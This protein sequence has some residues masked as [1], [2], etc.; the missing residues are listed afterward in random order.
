[1]DG[2]LKEPPRQRKPFRGFGPTAVSFGRPALRWLN[3]SIDRAA[4]R[5]EIR[6]QCPDT[7]GVYGMLDRDAQLIYVGMSRDLRSR[8]LSYFVGS[9][10]GSKQ[11][12]IASHAHQLVW[13][14]AGHELTARLRELELIRRWRPRFNAQGRPGRTSLGYVYLTATDAP[15]FRADTVPARGSRW[16]WGPLP[17]ERRTR[18]AAERL[19]HVFQLRDCSRDVPIRFADQRDLFAMDREAACLRG[20]VGGCLA[21]CAGRCTRPEYTRQIDS[22]RALLDGTDLGEL[23]RLQTAM[24]RAAAG[25]QFERAAS[26]RD[27]WDDLAYLV[28]QLELLRDVREH[29]W[30]VYPVPCHTGRTLWIVIAGGDVAGVRRAPENSGTGRRWRE[31]LDDVRRRRDSG[32]LNNLEDLGRIRLAVSWFRQNPAEMDCILTLQEADDYCRRCG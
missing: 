25:Q 32:Q 26:L 12:R 31:L 18:A 21:P 30:F 2:L 20:D 15:Q 13:E 14:V 8:V 24:E 16:S 3:L 1:M 5:R 29:Y 9:D 11:H 17:L 28:E 6:E 19:N 22:A 7:P 27:A 4:L 10:N 23:D